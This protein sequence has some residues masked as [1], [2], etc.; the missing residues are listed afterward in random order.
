MPF[1]TTGM[2]FKG[3]MLSEKSEREK[4]MYCMFSL[5]CKILKSQTYR[6]KSLEWSFP[7][8]GENVEYRVQTYRYEMNK[9]HGSN[10]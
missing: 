7:G 6:N 5:I 2:A 8:P 9:L 1:A 10:V 4:D 3:F